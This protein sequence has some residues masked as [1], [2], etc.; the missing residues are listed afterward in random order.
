MKLISRLRNWFQRKRRSKPKTGSLPGPLR[1]FVYLDEVSIYS[2]L[3]SRKGGI[4]TEVTESQTVSQQDEVAGSISAGVGSTKAATEARI[5]MGSVQGTQV[6]RKAIVQTSFKE[7]YELERTSC[8]LKPRN[9]DEVP[10]V[11]SV[12]DLR[13][14]WKELVAERWLVDPDCLSRGQLLEVEVELEADPIFRLASIIKTLWELIGKNEHIVDARLGAELGQMRSIAEVLDGLLVGLVPIRG[15]VAD[16][17]LIRVEERDVLLHKMIL[18]RMCCAASPQTT[19]AYIV[20]VAEHDLFWKDIRRILFSNS[21]Y[22]VYCRLATNGLVDRWHPIKVADVLAGIVPNF[23]ELMQD[24]AYQADQAL[25]TAGTRASMRADRDRQLN[26]QM[27][28]DYVKRLAA[29][30]DETL[31]PGKIDQIV[32]DLVVDA[33]WVESVDSRRPV[34]AEVTRQVDECLGKQTSSEI[35][36]VLRQSVVRD[37]NLI[38]RDVPP[39]PEQVEDDVTGSAKPSSR[40]LDA[41]IIAIYW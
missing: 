26:A 11:F 19:V 22:T 5:Q 4:A 7:L 6:L 2:I 12:E 41:E 16:Y 10:D 37:A 17:E 24:F 1:E 18:N 31:E 23:D 21:R 25:A 30:H 29:G 38:R 33:D 34:F 39:A 28:V 15:R 27:M 40:F 35:A 32:Q 8:S 20:G 14:Q 36:C 9:I 3:A 13:H